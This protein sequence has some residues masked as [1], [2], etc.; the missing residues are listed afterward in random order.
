MI[1]VCH[2]RFLH[3]R[4]TCTIDIYWNVCMLGFGFAFEKF[5]LQVCCKIVLRSFFTLHNTFFDMSVWLCLQMSRTTCHLFSVSA[6]VHRYWSC[7]EVN[8]HYEH[9]CVLCVSKGVKLESNFE[10]DFG[11]EWRKKPRGHGIESV[12]RDFS[13][14]FGARTKKNSVNVH[15]YWD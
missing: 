3:N 9:P 7:L 11:L 6:K 5:T 13:V 10:S 14:N 12:R 4:S 8:F 1:E 2:S 15:W